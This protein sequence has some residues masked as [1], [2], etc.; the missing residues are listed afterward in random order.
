[1]RPSPSQ[2]R[3]KTL[4]LV[5]RGAVFCLACPWWNPPCSPVKLRFFTLKTRECTF[6]PTRERDSSGLVQDARVYL[7]LSSTRFDPQLTPPRAGTSWWQF[8]ASPTSYSARTEFW[9]RMVQLQNLFCMVCFLRHTGPSRVVLVFVS[10]IH[11][12]AT[13]CSFCESATCTI[14][15]KPIGS[16]FFQVNCQP[17]VPF[18]R[19]LVHSFCESATWTDSF[20]NLRSSSKTVRRRR[21]QPPPPREQVIMHP[22]VSK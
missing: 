15:S 1:M 18:P 22:I 3:S 9:F 13:I 19:K 6:G 14:H 12:M 5:A 10:P 7:K 4:S 2:C 20:E 21:R 8:M 17:F 16:R 11:E